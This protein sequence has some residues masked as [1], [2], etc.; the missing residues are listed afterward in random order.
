MLFLAL[1]APLNQLLLYNSS[2]VLSKNL[3]SCSKACPILNNKSSENFGPK[4]CTP[5]GS[6][7]I[8]P[9]GIESPGTPAKL[10]LTVKTSDKYIFNGSSTFSP[11][12][13]GIV[14]ETGEIIASTFLYASSKSLIIK[15]LT[16]I[17]FL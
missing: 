1:R 2:G 15:V 4:N 11:I 8:N 6:P 9:E 5:T 3:V 16:F 14:G 10:Q 13:Q 7:L 12:F 17:A